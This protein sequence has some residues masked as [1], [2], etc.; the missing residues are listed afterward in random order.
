MIFTLKKPFYEEKKK[1]LR[2]A[3]WPTKAK[4]EIMKQLIFTLQNTFYEEKKSACG[5]R[6]GQ[7]KN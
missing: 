6:N 7:T 5:A 3:Q 2:R 4:I 1:R